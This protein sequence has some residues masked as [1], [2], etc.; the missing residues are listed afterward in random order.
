M[1]DKISTG[2]YY[3]HYLS[4]QSLDQYQLKLKFFVFSALQKNLHFGSL[5]YRNK[6]AKTCV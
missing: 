4:R 2:D 1:Q 3:M 6:K 5:Y